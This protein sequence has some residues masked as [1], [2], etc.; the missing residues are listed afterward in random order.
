[1][2]KSNLK[3][4]SEKCKKEIEKVEGDLKIA[5]EENT[6]WTIKAGKATGEEYRLFCKERNRYSNKCYRL[7]DKIKQLKENKLSTS[8]LNSLK[9]ELSSCNTVKY[10]L[11]KEL[12]SFNTVKYEWQ[13]GLRGIEVVGYSKVLNSNVF[14]AYCKFTNFM[15]NVKGCGSLAG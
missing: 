14:I 13:L 6:K 10:D 2:I 4:M 9:K 11:K 5:Q 3:E 7:E 8:E 12:S 1:M 15:H